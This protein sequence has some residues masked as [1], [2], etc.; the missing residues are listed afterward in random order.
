ME[1]AC[2]IR[3]GTH[4]QQ[5]DVLS[6]QQHIHYLIKLVSVHLFNCGVHTGHIPLHNAA[7]NIV[8]AHLV[9]GCL[10]ALDRRQTS[11]QHLLQRLLHLGIAVIT[12]LRGKTHHRRLA[13]LHR[14]SQ[15]TGRHKG[16]FI[17]IVQ[18]ILCDPL[19][20][21]GKRGHLR[22]DRM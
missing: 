7:Q 17:I 6:L 22:L 16:S 2:Q 5:I 15:L 11:P 14:A 12:Q 9:V 21:L 1:V 13:D 8:V 19:M 18:N 3:R 10:N 20:T 4:T